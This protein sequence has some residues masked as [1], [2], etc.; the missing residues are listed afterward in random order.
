M[1]AEGAGIDPK[2]HGTGP[3][4]GGTSRHDAANDLEMAQALN[5]AGP[6]AHAAPFADRN[7]TENHPGDRF[8]VEG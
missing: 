2:E 3:G 1:R 5:R 7:G 6:L 4:V 8:P